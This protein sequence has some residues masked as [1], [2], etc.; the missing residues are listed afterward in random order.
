M[1]VPGVLP[2]GGLRA[3]RVPV[4]VCVCVPGE[5]GACARPAPRQPPGRR[6]QPPGAPLASCRALGGVWGGAGGPGSARSPPPQLPPPPP[7]Q[8]RA[9]PGLGSGCE[10]AAAEGLSA[11]SAVL[12]SLRILFILYRALFDV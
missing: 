5:R 7:Q 8:H 9:C 3:P 4:R 6:P 12:M 10:A 1:S 2:P 11:G